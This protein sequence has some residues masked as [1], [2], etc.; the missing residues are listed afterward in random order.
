MSV[1]RRVDVPSLVTLTLILAAGCS[2]SGS[3]PGGTGGAASGTGGATGGGG[4]TSATGGAGGAGAGLPLPLVVD[5]HS[6]PQSCYG[7]A[8]VAGAVDQT[9]NSD[10]CLALSPSH[11]G[12]CWRIDYH[13]AP[14][15]DG[16]TA[17]GGCQWS[18]DPNATAALTIQPGATEAIFTAAGVAG[19]EVINFF[20]GGTPSDRASFVAQKITLTTTLTDYQIQIPDLTTKTQIHV[21]FGYTIVDGDNTTA[22][23]SFFVTGIEWVKQ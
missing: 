15:A 1:P 20:A 3:S 22:T 9:P 5:D 16:G 14:S 23:Q 2:S 4:T 12:K 11:A 21:P 13:P 17:Y 10:D 7:K 8:A 19:G 6:G 18:L